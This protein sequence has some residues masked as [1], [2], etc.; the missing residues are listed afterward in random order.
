VTSITEIKSKLA[1][2]IATIPS[3]RVS[4][5]IPDNP[6]PPVGI[7]NLDNIQY[8]QAM[9]QGLTLANFTVQIIVARASARSAQNRLDGFVANSGASSVKSALELNRTLD[10]L[11][12]DLRV[13]SVPNIGSITM[14]DQIYL[15]ADF[16]VAV[17]F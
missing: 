8:D 1:E 13:V 10:G 12:Q 15:A 5:Q 11:I 17:Y 2:R 7:I 3:L 6:Q 14:S 4:T 9:A 16:E